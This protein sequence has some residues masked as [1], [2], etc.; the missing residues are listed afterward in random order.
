M[1]FSCPIFTI[2]LTF[3][4]GGKM[5]TQNKLE[6]CNICNNFVWV[7]VQVQVQSLQKVARLNLDQTL[8]SLLKTSEKLPNLEGTVRVVLRMVKKK[9]MQV[10]VYIQ[11]STTSTRGLTAGLAIIGCKGVAEREFCTCHRF[12]FFSCQWSNPSPSFLMQYV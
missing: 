4:E 11:C 10:Y 12:L 1:C 9:K 5:A 8:D 7:Q 3:V 2:P 6:K